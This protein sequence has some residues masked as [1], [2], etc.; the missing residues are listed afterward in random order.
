M[1]ARVTV[2]EVIAVLDPDGV[3]GLLEQLENDELDLTFGINTANGLINEVCLDSDYSTDW[4]KTIELWLAA[5]YCTIHSPKTKQEAAKGLT[6]TYEGQTRLGLEFTRYG[7]QAK[8]LDYKGN[9][10]KIDNVPV[11]KGKL[12]ARVHYVGGYEDPRDPE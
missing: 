9:L 10:A 12:T 5:H 2:Q 1:A 4:L 11:G 8:T 7:Q 3:D 6:E